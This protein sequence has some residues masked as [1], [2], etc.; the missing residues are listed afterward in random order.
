[1]E[2]GVQASS[3]D[4]AKVRDV[5]QAAEDLGYAT[6]YFPDHFIYETGLGVYD[7]AQPVYEAATVLAALA[8][9]TTRVRLGTHVLCNQFRHPAL[10]AK[11]L[12]TLDHVSGGRLLAGMGAGWTRSEFDMMGI[13]FPPVS[14]RLAMLD[15]ALQVILALWTEERASFSGTYY[16][17]RDAVAAPKPLQRPHPPL[18]LG[19]NGKGVMRLAARYAD[20]VNIA[21]DLGKAGKVDAGRLGAF[22]SEAFCER[23]AFLRAEC[24][25]V[26]RP[27]PRLH[28]TAF[29]ITITD[30]AAASRAAAENFAGMLGLAPETV[31]R[32]PTILI[33]TPAELIAELTRREREDGLSEISIGMPSM[34]VVR[35]LGEE[36]L[37]HVRTPGG[38]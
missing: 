16:H 22:T 36:V 34:R 7:P 11:I 24:E 13:D 23:A 21:Q 32:M 29:I 4:F 2:L 26:G 17:L 19:G 3:G 12:T 35:R 31:R 38:A 1:M 18:M 8:M 37:P 9:A 28:A 10:T 25:A 6:V 27:M 15:E 14:T 33:G 5:V 30:T 20:V